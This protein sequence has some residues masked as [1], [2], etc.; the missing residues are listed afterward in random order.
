MAFI[1]RRTLL[2]GISSLAA[3][4]ALLPLPTFSRSTLHVGVVGGG[5]VGASI[6][7][8][9]AALGAKVTLFEKTALA[10]GATGN[11]FAWINASST[12]THYRKFRL[13]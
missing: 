11:S 5:I 8:H 9:L 2:A 1:K 12:N 10:A 4:S 13:A 7:L 3:T 6:A